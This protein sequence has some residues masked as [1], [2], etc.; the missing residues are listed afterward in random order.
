M[1]ISKNKPL[2]SAPPWGASKTV[3]R[4]D[5]GKWI[6]EDVIPPSKDGEF[7]RQEQK[8][9]SSIEAGGVY[10]PEAGRYHLYVSYA[11]PWAHRVLIGRKLKKLESFVGVSV[12]SPDMLERG[13]SFET[14]FPGSTGDLGLGK[15]Y[16]YEV[17]AEADPSFSGKVTVPVLFDLRTKSIV[18]N[19]SSEILRILN[20]AFS[21]LSRSTLDLYPLN[22]RKEIEAINADIYRNINNGVYRAGFARTQKAY[23]ASVLQVFEAL[24]RLERHLAQKSYL[25]GDTL[26]EADIRLSTTLIRFDAVYHGHFKCN[27]RQLRE[28]PE[29]SR[30]L[31][32]LSSQPEFRETTHFDH[33]KR[34][35][36]Y[37]HSSI[38]PSRVIPMGPALLLS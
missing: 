7:R 22:L 34:H 27:L 15:S 16:L 36:Y 11:C 17:Y 30:Y 38:N 12:L 2:L 32:G 26:T 31:R 19:E 29:L 23:E 14:Q 5:N 9:R 6:V 10:P 33:I 3:G 20:A 8:F 24:D 21:G 13:W 35:Y 37:S 1:T 25:V 4:L 18:N 28:Y